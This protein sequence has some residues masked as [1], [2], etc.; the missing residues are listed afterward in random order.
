MNVY[1]ALRLESTSFRVQHSTALATHIVVVFI[2]SCAFFDRNYVRKTFFRSSETCTSQFI[3]CLQ[4]WKQPTAFADDIKTKWR[5]HKKF[6]SSSCLAFCSRKLHL[7]T[8]TNDQWESNCNCMWLFCTIMRS[9]VAVTPKFSQHNLCTFSPN[10]AHEIILL[11]EL[12]G[13]DNYGG[14][15]III[16]S[17][18]SS[19]RVRPEC[20]KRGESVLKHAQSIITINKCRVNLNTASG[21]GVWLSLGGGGMSH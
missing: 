13:N 20:R 15:E 5:R 6:C 10:R 3:K 19:F 4:L 1:D 7:H 21:S 17:S 2:V 18:T 12:D 16:Y 8:L 11:C 9:A 14:E